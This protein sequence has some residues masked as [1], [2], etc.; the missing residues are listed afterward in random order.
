MFKKEDFWGNRIQRFIKI[1]QM[2]KILGQN[3]K[4]L[5]AVQEL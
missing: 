2:K 3:V 1:N 4:K 5:T